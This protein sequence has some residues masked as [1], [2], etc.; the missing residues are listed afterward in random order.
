[1]SMRLARGVPSQERRRI[2]Q[3]QPSGKHMWLVWHPS[4]CFKCCTIQGVNLSMRKC[5][6]NLGMDGWTYVCDSVIIEGV[7]VRPEGVGVP[8]LESLNAGD[9]GG[10]LTESAGTVNEE[11]GV[12]DNLG[13]G[14]GVLDRD[15]VTL[16][17]ESSLLDIGLV[18]VPDVDAVSL[19]EE[20]QEKLGDGAFNLETGKE[21]LNGLVRLRGGSS[22]K[23]AC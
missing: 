8:A 20:G 13:L 10:E 5:P 12:V 17:A 6:N 14:G 15:N 2:I 1:M 7:E 18:T 23:S 22:E 19:S 9:L 16:E 4:K 3:A 21:E 11:L